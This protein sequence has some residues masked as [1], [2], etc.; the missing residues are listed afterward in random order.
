M[1]RDMAD[2]GK[3]DRN[4]VED[5]NKVYGQSRST[6][7][8]ADHGLESGGPASGNTAGQQSSEQSLKRWRCPVCGYIYEG[9][10]PPERCPVCDMPGKE[11]QLIS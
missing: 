1:M 7:T 2:Q 9:E 3:I 8:A 5:L 6:L 4:I 10:E 11:Y